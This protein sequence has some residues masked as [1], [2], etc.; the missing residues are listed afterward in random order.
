MKSSTPPPGVGQVVRWKRP[1]RL[2][3]PADET[4]TQARA[5]LTQARESLR[6]HVDT[7]TLKP[8]L[9]TDALG[10]ASHF[11]VLVAD[12]KVPRVTCVSA[13]VPEFLTPRP[14]PVT[15]P[16]LDAPDGATVDG[17]TRVDDRW[18]VAR[19]DSAPRA[20]RNPVA[21]Y[22]AS[23]DSKHSRRTMEVGLRRILK[24]LGSDAD[25][26]VWPWVEMRYAEV[27][28]ARAA[29]VK[30]YKPAAINLSLCALRG[31]MHEAFRLELITG[32]HWARVKDV[33]GVKGTSLVSGRCIPQGELVALFEVCDRTTPVGVRDR[34]IL[35]VLRV[36]GMR[37]AELAKI[38]LVDLDVAAG[39]VKIIGKGNKERLCH[40]GQAVVDVEA[41]LEVRGRDPGPLNARGGGSLFQSWSTK[42]KR[43]RE[44]LTE[45]GVY[46][47]LNGIAAKAGVPKLSPHDFRRTFVSDLLDAGVDLVIAQKLAGH[48]DPATTARYD[49]REEPVRKAAV[50][51]LNIPR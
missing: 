15:D 31:V 19:T 40:L 10:C 46:S 51:K 28:A 16:D 3:K 23:L 43:F 12:T 5:A 14:F 33:A 26:L 18:E 2:T 44:G 50:L 49:R 48:E 8:Q 30:G 1:A 39:E 47:I 20:I 11:A 21:V 42:A 45:S 32:E 35:A 13:P 29:L 22:L 4:L 25:I 36:T 38:T 34:A 37:R 27:V 17:F 7:S 9:I 6:Q 24:A 41:W